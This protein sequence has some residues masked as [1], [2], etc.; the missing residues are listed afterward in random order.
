MLS[1]RQFLSNSPTLMNAGTLLGQLSASFVLPVRDSM[2]GIFES[3]K[4]MALVQRTGGGT[5]FSFSI[6]HPRGDLVAS[7]AGAA[8]GPVVGVKRDAALLRNFN[9]SVLV[10]GGFMKAARLN[11]WYDLVNP[12]TSQVSGRLRAGEVF[13]AIVEAAWQTGDPGPLFEDAINR[14]NPTPLRGRFE[15]T[16]PCGEIPSSPLASKL[17]NRLSRR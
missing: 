14:A 7:T 10:T 1:A 11:D 15:A 8:S 13:R 16:N 12:R 6:L 4:Q 5:G 3:L 17:G 2:E 9:L